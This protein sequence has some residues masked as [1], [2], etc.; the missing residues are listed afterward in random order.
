MASLNK[1]DILDLMI[2]ALIE[3]EKILNTLLECL[4]SGKIG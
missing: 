4:D 3:L 2:K 1:L